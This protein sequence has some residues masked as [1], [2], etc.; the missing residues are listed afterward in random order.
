MEKKI[1]VIISGGGS[2]GHLFPAIAIAKALQKLVLDI[3]ILFVGAKGKIEM[4]LVP[5]N[6]FNIEGLWISGLQRKKLYKNLL[7]PFKL[8][9][10]LLKARKIIK[11]FKP[12][13]V[14][15][16]GGFASGPLI[17]VATMM[18]IPALIQEQNSFPGITNRLLA[19]KVQI[20]CV[21]YDNMDKYFPSSKIRFT[22]NPVRKEITELNINKDEALK[23]F[24]L[25][26]DKKTVLVIGG[27]L[28]A[29]TINES[30]MLSLEL[31]DKNNLQ[32]IWQT[33][34]YYYD[35]A[36]AAIKTLQ[37]KGCKTQIYVSAF[38]NEM[39][40]A[41]AASDLIVSRAGAIAISE[42]CIVGKPIILVPSPNVAED[43]QTKNALKLYTMNA[44]MM[45]KDQEAKNKLGAKIITLL[46]NKPKI[47]E[48]TSN[49]KKLAKKKAA[50]KIADEA[51]KLILQN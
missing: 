23:H 50:D 9:S 2:G 43:H 32:L 33:G 26:N 37:N 34:K 28:G 47:E 35:T 4:E 42:L 13:I 3:E 21:A 7:F 31:F 49:I 45:I 20:I 6:G 48:L 8:I 44:A 16:T 36:A 18:K 51:L 11:K 29:K 38:I 24:G 15:G 12:D 10:S 22:G 1:K 17:N 40:Y 19:P 27:S 5:K 39:D 46:N 25:D 41:Y 30:I 14:I